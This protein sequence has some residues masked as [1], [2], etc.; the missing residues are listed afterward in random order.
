[1]FSPILGVDFLLDAVVVINFLQQS[2]RIGTRTRQQYVKSLF[3][4]RSMLRHEHFYEDL[5]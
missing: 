1:M 3:K 2:T 5:R 4:S